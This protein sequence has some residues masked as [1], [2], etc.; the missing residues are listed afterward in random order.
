MVKYKYIDWICIGAA[1]LAILLTLLLMFGEQLGLPKASANPG[2]VT[3]LFDDSRVHVIDIQIADWGVFI[4]D[5]EQEEYVACTIEIDG[6]AFHNIGLRAK[7]NNSLRLTEEYGLSRYSL[8]LEF[9]QFLDGG[10]YYGLDKFSLDA[11]FQ[12]NSYLKTYMVYDMMAFMG[13]PAPLCSYVWVTVNGED[14]GLFLAVEE[15]EEAFARRNFGN[16]HGKLYKPDYR[17]LNAENADVALRYI[18]DNPDSYPGIFEN[19]KF[20]VSEA[21][22]K[23]MTEALKTLSTGEKLETAV[24]VDEVLRYFTVQVFVMNWDSYLGHTGHNY[25][26]YEENGILSILPWDYNLAFGTYALGMTDPIKDPNILINYPINTPAE[27]EVMLNRP[28]YHN[29]M[30]HDEYFARYHAYFDKLL[31]EYFESGRFAVTLRQTAKQIAPYVQ[32]DPTAFCSYEDHQLAV[33]T[34]EEVCLLRAE[35]IRGQLD[36][37]IPATIRGQQENPDA[38]VDASVVKLTDL[39]DFE[40]LE[41][42][43]ERQ[44]AALRDIT[45]KST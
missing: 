30:K 17:S 6:E 37:E 11:S 5:A 4:E 40:D 35:S 34:L 41:S 21:D 2:Y 22:Q 31:S 18:D 28:L 27:G 33:D 13:V 24:N 43:K 1:V 29:L 26:L 19:A 10:N 9:D 36:G 25:F 39:G 45:G 23:R 44:D 38:K 32:K 16:D 7:G 20:K 12:D 15:P 42:A 14:W 3:R 8:K